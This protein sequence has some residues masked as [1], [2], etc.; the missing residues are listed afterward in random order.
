M[1]CMRTGARSGLRWGTISL[2]TTIA[3]LAVSTAPADAQNRRSKGAAATSS[4]RSPGYSALVIDANS[5]AVLHATNADAMRHP[6]SLTKVM[7]LFMLFE[8]LDAGKLTLESQLRV[9]EHAADQAPTKLGLREGGS[10]SVEDAI[11]G[12][13]TRSANDAAV[14]VAEHL[15]GSEEE[16]A[17]QMTRRA[18]SLGMTG[19]VYR[20]ASGLPDSAQ[21]TTA[22]DQ[23]ILGRAIQERFP[24]YYRYF[25]TRTFTYRGQQ[26]S[27][28]NK[29]LGRVEGVDGIKTGYIRASGFN[30]ITSVRRNGRHVVAVVLG[31]AS[32]A[33]RDASMRQLL[34]A[35]V[36]KASTRRTAPMIAATP[37]RNTAAPRATTA[38]PEF[39]APDT[40][41]PDT[42]TPNAIAADRFDLASASSAPSP[43]TPTAGSNDPIRPIVV[44]TVPVQPGTQKT[45]K[46]SQPPQQPDRQPPVT[47]TAEPPAPTTADLTATPPVRTALAGT[48]TAVL[49]TNPSETPTETAP[50]ATPARPPAR[51][52]WIIQVGA[53]P[54][55]SEAQQRLASVKQKASRLLN[56][57]TPFTEPVQRGETTLYR[58]RFAVLDREQAEAACRYLRRNDV[59]CVALRN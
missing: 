12:M 30:L 54:A 9:S 33:A 3:L 21:V 59:D 38:R 4:A 35:H 27:N 49:P 28:H 55:E 41:T 17:R 1:L 31:G 18:R 37:S 57:A 36:D 22:R 34:A 42:R 56:A 40:K 5:G 53:F 46:T 51:P 2:C 58:A 26:I 39:R 14:V 24:R 16:F 29:L 6:A 20:N 15:A 7:T 48:A 32:A 43:T 45:A 44:R 52:G 8:R 19:T 50:A 47:A 11:K 23:A 10:I 25:S 13:V